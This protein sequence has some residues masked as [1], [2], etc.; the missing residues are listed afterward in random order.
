MIRKKQVLFLPVIVGYILIATV[1]CIMLLKWNIIFPISYPIICGSIGG[2][3]SIIFQNNKLEIDYCVADNLLYFESF[4][5]IMLPNLMSV[6]G[7][8]AIES[9]FIMG[10]IVNV[11]KGEYLRLL[12]YVICGYSQ[13]FIPNILK[14][15]ELKD[16]K[17]EKSND[18]EID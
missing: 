7:Y 14:N 10:N 2:A 1:M 4:K 5:L 15:F 17:K 9:E 3:L 11:Q 16:I 8:M 13:T 12:I 18:K 6:I